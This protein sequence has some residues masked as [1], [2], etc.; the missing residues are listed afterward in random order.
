MPPPLTWH[1]FQIIV[2]VLSPIVSICHF[3]QCEGHWLLSDVLTFAISIC[4]KLKKKIENL[5]SFEN[6]MEE[7]SIAAFE[8]GFLAFNIKKKVVLFKILFKNK[9]EENKAHNMFSLML[10]LWFKNLCLM[11]SFIDLE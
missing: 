6:F 11:S 2:D 8:S 3:N 9:Y 10:Y 1:I 4:L 5:V 7:E